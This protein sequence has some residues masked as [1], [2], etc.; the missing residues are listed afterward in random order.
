MTC[1]VAHTEVLWLERPWQ[2]CRDEQL[3]PGRRISSRTRNTPDNRDL[4]IIRTTHTADQTASSDFNTFYTVDL[5]N[6]S[7]IGSCLLYYWAGSHT[8][9]SMS[10]I[11]DLLERRL[12]WFQKQEKQENME[13]LDE[14][15]QRNINGPGKSLVQI[16]ELTWCMF[17]MYLKSDVEKLIPILELMLM[18]MGVL[19]W[20][21]WPVEAKNSARV[22][23]KSTAVSRSVL[24][25][26][27]PI[28]QTLI[29]F[30]RSKR[31][32]HLIPSLHHKQKHALL[33]EFTQNDERIEETKTIIIATRNPGKAED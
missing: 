16:M 33:T 7:P 20:Q 29:F 6:E 2:R 32:S 14:S 10:D 19:V 22:P 4:R 31:P 9:Y 28:R 12:P 13:S 26:F 23:W 1:K 15:C 5:L 30:S 3:G 27:G 18:S 25:G 17:S 8:V 11:A 21:V 24:V